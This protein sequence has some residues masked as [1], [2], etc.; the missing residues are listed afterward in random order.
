MKQDVFISYRGADRALARKLEQRLRSRWGSRVFRDETGLDGGGSWADQLRAQLE[1]AT[2]VLA[3][4]GPGWSVNTDPTKEDWVRAELLD[5]VDRGTPILP[6]LVGDPDVLRKRL[7]DLPAAFSRQAIVV[8]EDMPLSSVLEIAKRLR[9]L[10]AFDDDKGS[11]LA[12]G[13]SDLYSDLA[14]RDCLGALDGTTPRKDAAPTAKVPAQPDKRSVFIE[15]GGGS[16][17]S[18]LLREIIRRRRHHDAN[19]KRFVAVCGIDAH[20][21]TRSTHAVMGAWLTSLARS[22]EQLP[23]RRDRIRYGHH[24]VDAVLKH[25]PDLLSRRVV[26]VSQLLALGDD[27]HDALVLE[28]TRRPT[29]RWAPYPPRRLVIQ[30][31]SVLKA[32]VEMETMELDLV[33]ADVDAIDASSRDLIAELLQAEPEILVVMAA[34]PSPEPDAEALRRLLPAVSPEVTTRVDRVRLDDPSMWDETG[35]PLPQ[36]LA[37]HRIDIDAGLI[38]HLKEPN[39]Y[40]ALARL[41]Y[42]ADHGFIVDGSATGAV[43]SSMDA[44]TPRNGAG[45]GGDGRGMQWRLKTTVGVPSPS[46][47][48]LLDHMID[49]YVPKDLQRLIAAGALVGRTFPFAVAYEATAR[50]EGTDPE[51]DAAERDRVWAR[52]EASDP[53]GMVLTTYELRNGERFV[54]FALDDLVPHIVEGLSS[55][56]RIE[57]HTRVAEAFASS[58]A[59]TDKSDFEAVFR[60]VASAADHWERA[61]GRHLRTAADAHR[62][63]AEWAERALAYREGEHHYRVAIRLL[64]QLI[65]DAN[66]STHDHEDL[67]I[68]S[69]CQYRLG[70]MVRLS[71]GFT[72]DEHGSPQIY[73]TGALRNL[74][75]LRELL[76]HLDVTKLPALATETFAR[77]DIPGPDRVQ[78]LLRLCDALSGYIKLDTAT[79]LTDNGEHQL[80]REALFETLRSAELAG[81]EASSRWLLAA[82]AS[83]LAESLA[84]E[85]MTMVAGH[86]GDAH[87]HDR[88]H[89]LAVEALFSIERVVGLRTPTVAEERDLAEAKALAREVFG[90][91]ITN[92]HRNPRMAEWVYRKLNAHSGDIRVAEDMSTDFRLGTFLLS[93]VQLDE[94]PKGAEGQ[95]P[96]PRWTASDE[97][98]TAERLLERYT[99]WARENGLRDLLASAYNRLA[100]ARLLGEGGVTP[101]KGKVS[102]LLA[103]A[104]ANAPDGSVRAQESELLFGLHYA[105]PASADVTEAERA[106]ARLSTIQSFR[107][108][109]ARSPES[110]AWSDDRV[111]EAGWCGVAELLLPVCPALGLKAFTLAAEQLGGALIAQDDNDH[112][113][114][115]ARAYAE[116]YVQAVTDSRP[117]SPVHDRCIEQLVAVRLSRRAIRRKKATLTKV[118]TLFQAHRAACVEAEAA[119]AEQLERDLRWATYVYDWYDDVEPAR[120]LVLAG[121]WHREVTGAQWATPQ[122]LRGPL[123]I[124]VLADQ[125]DAR[126]VL[127]TE[128]FDRIARLVENRDIGATEASPLEM[129]FF[130][131]VE[132]ASGEPRPR[133]GPAGTVHWSELAQQTG[134]LEAAYLQARAERVAELAMFGR[135]IETTASDAD[136]SADPASFGAP[137]PDTLVPT[138]P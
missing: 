54:T 135:P 35:S 79:W 111:L 57:V 24:L 51:A 21:T 102:D 78:H 3:L 129:V 25:G 22:I 86:P 138:G 85:A 92:I 97:L 130:L 67:L 94:R 113:L 69:N 101:E 82:A 65:A 68:V 47:G 87:V 75:R 27:S 9:Q 10:G 7:G 117:L 112:P 14:L 132:L 96:Q 60:A 59:A 125:F 49:E 26:S 84:N 19:F 93:L 44:T 81:G 73:F 116:N 109:L 20:D 55:R 137:H 12:A 103:K 89:D 110:T 83:R 74:D 66:D 36:W 16:G 17:R 37:H 63:A 33:V 8:P 136:D 107:R 56:E 70:Q 6:V 106:N 127:G 77:D 128:R 104:R 105:L 29:E 52:L 64:S 45:V 91:I 115:I 34:S 2:V 88:A 62:R 61:G 1:E 50:V 108:A 43:E 38:E 40:Y 53:D 95:R 100:I 114:R 72:G 122:L 46:H 13:R 120:L 32:F 99:D 18:A 131:A 123:T 41:W 5:A 98:V 76:R 15:G 119:D 39:P 4:V 42:L 11:S 58:E 126:S 133:T 23:L 71:A 118:A 134:H 30:A 80:A 124:S 28:A 90:R 121:E 31:A 48:T